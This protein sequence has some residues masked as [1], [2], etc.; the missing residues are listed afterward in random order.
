[1]RMRV[2]VNGVPAVIRRKHME[3]CSE[4]VCIYQVGWYRRSDS[5]CPYYEG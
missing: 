2:D 1:M 3:V 4:W 5:F